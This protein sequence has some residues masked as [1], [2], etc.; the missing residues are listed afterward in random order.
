MPLERPKLA[1][2]T[3][4]SS[5]CEASAWQAVDGD[6]AGID[7][8]TRQFAGLDRGR[9]DGG[10][11]EKDGQDHGRDEAVHSHGIIW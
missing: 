2:G 6:G 1:D 11:T 5:S 3:W 4:L 8:A 9:G 10:M 7:R